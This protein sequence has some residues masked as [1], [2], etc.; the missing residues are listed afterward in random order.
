MRDDLVAV[1]IEV[2]PVVGAAA[3]GAAED[4]CVEVASGVEVVDWKGD[5]KG[6]DGHG[7]MIPRREGGGQAGCGAV[8]AASQTRGCRWWRGEESSAMSHETTQ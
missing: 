8:G 5:V 7:S 6:L 1:E 2:D 3:F 4:G